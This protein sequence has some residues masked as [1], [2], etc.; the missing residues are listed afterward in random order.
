VQHR[1][2]VPEHQQLGVPGKISAD[3][4]AI[5]ANDQRISRQAILSSIRAAQGP[6]I[7][8]AAQFPQP[9]V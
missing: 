8:A 6:G 5:R 9:R 7:L 4:K 2:L 1:V 3:I